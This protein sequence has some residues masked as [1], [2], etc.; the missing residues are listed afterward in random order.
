MHGIPSVHPPTHFPGLEQGFPSYSPGPVTTIPR[1]LQRKAQRLPRRTPLTA[2][3]HTPGLRSSAICARAH[4]VRASAVYTTVPASSK[5]KERTSHNA[6]ASPLPK[7]SAPALSA[8]HYTL[9]HAPHPGQL[10]VP[11]LNWLPCS[12]SLVL[13]QGYIFNCYI[14]FYQ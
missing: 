5:P 7:V 8:S 10:A 13:S 4:A 12:P 9:L 1:R 6:S 3:P 2:S 11:A 14:F